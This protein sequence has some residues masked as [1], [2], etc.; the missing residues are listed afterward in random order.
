MRTGQIFFSYSRN[1]GK[2]ALRLGEDL[3]KAGVD[4]WIDQIDIPPSEPWDEEIEKALT[5]SD[6]LLVILSHTSVASDNVL[7]EIN[8]ALESKKQVLPIL[9][10][11]NIKK[12]FNIGR[13]QHI[14]FTGSYENGLNLLLKALS[15]EAPLQVV[16]QK[17]YRRIA[18]ISII[19]VLII[20]TAILVKITL[21][22][23]GTA[24]TPGL[25]KEKV[26]TENTSINVSGNWSSEEM[27]NPFD[28]N[29]KYKLLLDFETMGNAIVGSLKMISTVKGND[30]AV[31]KGIMDGKVTDNAISFYTLE[32]SFRGSENVSYKNFYL[33]SILKDEIKF[34]LQSDRPWGF[35][36]QKFLARRTSSNKTE[37]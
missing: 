2:F 11:N 24:D 9:L 4:I 36:G 27:T 28:D 1:D 29:D 31:K 14:D 22:K 25:K 35:P 23:P 16:H 34:S 18:F 21:L 6:C 7:N 8:Y 15:L 13:L 12:P 17:P 19:A 26:S 32:E 20:I 30:Y 3:R 10:E 5:G 33:G 37:H